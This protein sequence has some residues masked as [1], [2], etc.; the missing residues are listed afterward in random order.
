VSF[1]N[2]Q[3]SIDIK[4]LPNVMKAWN[5]LKVL[6]RLSPIPWLCIGEFNEVVSLSEK[7]GGGGRPNSQMKKFQSVLTECELSDLGFRGPKY[8]WSNYQKGQTLIKER[9]DR[10]VANSA[11]SELFPAAEV[12][13]DFSWN[14]D[15]ALL[16]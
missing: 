11:W 9:L 10:G 7:W 13:V 12:W 15:H 1:E 3:V 6:G 2:L 4:M 14:S 16:I 5:L 8:T